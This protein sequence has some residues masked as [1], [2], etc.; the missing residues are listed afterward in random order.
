MPRPRT[1]TICNK[2][3]RHIIEREMAKKG[4]TFAD[5]AKRRRCDVRTVRE[6][7]RDIGTRRHRIQTLRQFSLALK[8]PA[9]WLVRLLQDK[10]FRH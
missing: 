6:F 2:E 8:R 3:I 10:G 9:D 5:I 4:L 7:F 1:T